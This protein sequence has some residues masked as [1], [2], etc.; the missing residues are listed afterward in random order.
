MRFTKMLVKIVPMTFAVAMLML[1]AVMCQSTKSNKADTI[2]KSTDVTVDT[3]VKK[4]DMKN[5]KTAGDTLAKA[6]DAGYWTCTMHPEIHKAESGNCPICG[7]K[8]VFKKSDKD[9][10]KI[11]NIDH[12]K[13][14]M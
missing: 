13:M 2:E 1:G 4:M 12:S 10:V 14:K 8:L 7:M 11:K 5:I 9:T 6:A 3:S